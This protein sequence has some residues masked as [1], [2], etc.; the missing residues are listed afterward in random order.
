MEV[1]DIKLVYRKGGL[2][3][4]RNF[5]VLTDVT[6][7]HLNK[8]EMMYERLIVNIE[9][10]Q[11]SPLTFTH[12]LPYIASILFTHVKKLC[13]HGNPLL[14]Q[15]YYMNIFKNSNFLLSL[16]FIKHTCSNIF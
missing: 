12:D 16:L 14:E 13:N 3:L 10:H 1:Y 6:F 7:L 5:Y 9:V 2:P 15:I 4:L 8:I 11:G